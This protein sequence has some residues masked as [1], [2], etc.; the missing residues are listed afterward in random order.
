MS[1]DEVGKELAAAA[2][3]SDVQVMQGDI[4]WSSSRPEQQQLGWVCCITP[5]SDE[6]HVYWQPQGHGG[7]PDSREPLS[8][9][10]CADRALIPGDIVRR[11][12]AGLEPIGERRIDR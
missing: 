8:Q 2:R 4:V 12:D 5:E 7:P 11:C 1:G 3:R 10:R 6:G 9:L